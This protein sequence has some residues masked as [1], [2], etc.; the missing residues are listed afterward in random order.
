MKFLGICFIL[1]GLFESLELIC[2][3]YTLQISHQ[4]FMRGFLLG[5]SAGLSKIMTRN[6]V[7]LPYACIWHG[8]FGGVFFISTIYMEI[9]DKTRIYLLGSF[10]H[11]SWS[12]LGSSNKQCHQ[13]V[14]LLKSL[15]L[16]PTYT[17]PGNKQYA[18]YCDI[19]YLLSDCR[20]TQMVK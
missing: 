5:N 18:L 17:V 20:L 15:L 9:I 13:I 11:S 14:P 7:V 16:L 12:V 6:L 8:L 2:I 4:L 3:I 10:L 19:L 1:R